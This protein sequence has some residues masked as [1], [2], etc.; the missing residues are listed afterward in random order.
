MS[1]RINRVLEGLA[2][3]VGKVGEDP[4]WFTSAPPKVDLVVGVPDIE[5]VTRPAVLLAFAEAT[6]F[7]SNPTDRSVEQMVGTATFEAY[8]IAGTSGLG[9]ATALELHDLMEDVARAICRNYRLTIDDD[10]TD[11]LTF[12]A[13]PSAMSIER[14]PSVI[15]DVGIGKV[16]VNVKL[17]FPSREEGGI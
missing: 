2:Y 1:G 6:D 11:A 9:E 8:C 10:D 16:T 3:A 14:E 13:W 15:F 5:A 4:T 12:H 17:D 7:E